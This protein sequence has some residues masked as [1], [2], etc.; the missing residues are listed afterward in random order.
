MYHRWL[1]PRLLR[2]SSPIHATGA[3]QTH[4]SH[5]GFGIIDQADVENPG[6]SSWTPV[7]F[8]RPDPERVDMEAFHMAASRGKAEF[9]AWELWLLW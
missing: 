5:Q 7:K 6:I 9:W 2:I 8:A 4:I 1:K 3:E